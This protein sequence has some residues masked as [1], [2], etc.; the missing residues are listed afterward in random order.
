[1]DHTA[2]N[3]SRPTGAPDEVVCCQVSVTGSY[4]SPTVGQDL[5]KKLETPPQTTIMLPVHTAWWKARV[6]TL[7]L[8][9]V[10]DQVSVAGSY[11]PPVRVVSVG[12]RNPPHTI[13]LSPVQTAV[14]P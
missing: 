1:P 14:W 13:I 10:G 6:A 12:L 9:R 11:R 4:R 2:E 7:G 5:V 3:C 8:S